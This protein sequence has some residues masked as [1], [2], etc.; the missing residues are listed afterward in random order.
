MKSEILIKKLEILE[1][2]QL[3]AS[4]LKSQEIQCPYC[5]AYTNL[6]I[7]KNQHWK[8]KKCLKM[9][10]LYLINKPDDKPSEFDINLKLNQKINDVSMGENINTE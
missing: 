6:L 7:I 9:K 3:R 4:L 2:Q 5:N 1:R 8:G 10:D